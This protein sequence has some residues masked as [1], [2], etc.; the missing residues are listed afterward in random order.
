MVTAAFAGFPAA[1]LAFLRQLPTRDKAWFAANRPDYERTILDP[2]KAFAE[3]IGARLQGELSPAIVVEPRVNGAIAPINRDLRFSA[4]KTLYKDHL[5]FRWWEG[6]DK[7]SSPTLFVRLAADQVGF[8]TGVSFATPDRWRE[9][10]ADVQTGPLLADAIETLRGN[11]PIA[12]VGA[13]LK[14]PPAPWTADHPRSGLLLHK[15]AFQVRWSEPTPSAVTTADFADWCMARLLHC[16]SIQRW[17]VA[18]LGP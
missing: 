5:L 11:K 18:H 1:G 2:A 13:D 7:Q 17:L 15:S 6:G 4:D 14:R 8:A 3:A 9:R 10:V 12:V 16:A